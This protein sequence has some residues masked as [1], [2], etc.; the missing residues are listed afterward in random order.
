MLTSFSEYLNYF[1]CIFKGI[2]LIGDDGQLIF[3]VNFYHLIRIFIIF[4]QF[5]DWIYKTYE[6]LTVRKSR[7]KNR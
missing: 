1:Y 7:N 3:F 2:M 4:L 6:L 5:T